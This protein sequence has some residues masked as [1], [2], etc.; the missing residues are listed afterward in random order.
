MTDQT[1]PFQ[2]A[3]DTR[4]GRYRGGEG[5]FSRARLFQSA[6]DTRVG[7]YADAKAHDAHRLDCFNPRPTR[8]SGDTYSRQSSPTA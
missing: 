7:R 2:S 3:P 1:K 6:P 8:V 4:V 5:V